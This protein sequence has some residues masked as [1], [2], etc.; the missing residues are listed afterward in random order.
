MFVCNPSGFMKVILWGEH[1]DTVEENKT[2]V[3]NKVRVC[4]TSNERYLSTPKTDENLINIAESFSES[5]ASI[6]VVS[7]KGSNG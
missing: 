4:V 2:Y 6:Q 1:T 3:F 7:N 5:L